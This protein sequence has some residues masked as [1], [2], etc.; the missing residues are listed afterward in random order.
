MNPF[1]GEVRPF[2]GNYA[3]LNWALCD[4]SLHP[5]SQYPALFAVIGKAFGG[6]GIST[7][8]LPN[9]M[10]RVP[11][12]AGQGPGLQA[13]APGAQVGVTTWTL[14][15]SDTPPHTHTLEANFNNGDIKAPEAGA[16]IAK[17][18][19][20][21]AYVPN[22]NQGLAPMDTSSVSPFNGG[23]GP[24]NNLQPYLAVTYII[25]TAGVTPPR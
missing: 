10:D 20:G 12:G 8:G 7:F 23:G 15:A 13:Y 18:A 9:L 11:L 17:S 21:S 25:A 2:G 16:A 5:I 6:D 24:H 4:G 19:P 22:T 3:P 1:I 14:T